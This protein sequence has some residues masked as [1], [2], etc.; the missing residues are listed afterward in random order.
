MTLPSPENPRPR[1]RRGFASMDPEVRRELAR[2][3]GKTA[4][5]RG[6]AHEWTREE[7]ANAGR[8]GGRVIAAKRGSDGM[9]ALGRAGGVA[10]TRRK[11]DGDPAEGGA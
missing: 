9:A 3:G 4:H 11:Q 6:C 2:K 7:A 1:S 8:K 10:R 5:A